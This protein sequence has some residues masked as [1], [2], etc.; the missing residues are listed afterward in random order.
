[1]KEVTKEEYEDFINNYSGD[2]RSYKG[3][4]YSDSTLIAFCYDK[5]YFIKKQNKQIIPT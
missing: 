5:H 3:K 1:M 4:I 2:I